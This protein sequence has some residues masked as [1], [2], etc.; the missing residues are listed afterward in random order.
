MRSTVAGSPPA[1]RYRLVHGPRQSRKS[2]SPVVVARLASP[3]A[4]G[5]T[6]LLRHRRRGVFAMGGADKPMSDFPNGNAPCARGT[7][8]S[9]AGENA[10]SLP[11]L[12]R[13]AKH[14]NRVGRRL[15]F[16][17]RRFHAPTERGFENWWAYASLLE[18]AWRGRAG[19]PPEF[20]SGF[21]QKCLVC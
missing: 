7:A 21:V 13:L 18:T 10:D 4:R 9:N 11:M 6:S 5:G 20:E 14:V 15:G 19:P 12:Y 3:R 8:L 1:T 17:V 2:H 16:E